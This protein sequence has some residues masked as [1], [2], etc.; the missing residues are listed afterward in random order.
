[1]RPSAPHWT[2]LCMT[3]F[4]ASFIQDEAL[5]NYLGNEG[6]NA[7]AYQYGLLL[8]GCHLRAS[9][10]PPPESAVFC[11]S[12]Q[13]QR[14]RLMNPFPAGGLNA[15]VAHASNSAQPPE[16]THLSKRLPSLY[17][18][19]CLPSPSAPCRVKK[20]LALVPAPRRSLVWNTT[21]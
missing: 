11:G 7:H 1:M 19:C 4:C 5:M 15:A 8:P 10:H 20:V 14:S 13:A 12:T 16:A 18:R 2:Q 21:L 6:G 3:K 9:C 17:T